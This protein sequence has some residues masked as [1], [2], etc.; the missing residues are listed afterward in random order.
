MIKALLCKGLGF[1][2]GVRLVPTH[3]FNTG[4]IPTGQAA[5]RR[6]LLLRVGR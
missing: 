6:L 2:S 4:S 3:G 1:S 5:R